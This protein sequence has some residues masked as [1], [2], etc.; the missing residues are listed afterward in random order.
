MKMSAEKPT[1]WLVDLLYEHD[2][3]TTDEMEGSDNM[4]DG[5]DDAQRAELEAT[6]AM[7]GEVRAAMPMEEPRASVRASILEAAHKQAEAQVAASASARTSGRRA[8][9]SPR[10]STESLWGGQNLY[11]AMSFAAVLCVLIG[12][13]VIAQRM[14]QPAMEA[15]F[16]EANSGVTNEVSFGGDSAPAPAR[17]QLAALEEEAET[18]EPTIAANDFPEIAQ[19][20]QT[21]LG[22]QQEDPAVGNKTLAMGDNKQKEKLAKSMDKGSGESWLENRSSRRE[23][24]A[25]SRAQAPKKDELD[26]SSLKSLIGSDDSLDE[27]NYRADASKAKPSKK[28]SSSKSAYTYRGSGS[29]TDLDALAKNDESY[30]QNAQAPSRDTN[31]LFGGAEGDGTAQRAPATSS[32]DSMAGNAMLDDVEAPAEEP[33]PMPTSEAPADDGGYARSTESVEEQ[34]SSRRFKIADRL[35]RNRDERK[36]SKSAPAPRKTTSSSTG[37]APSAPEVSATSPSDEQGNKDMAIRP[38]EQSEKKAEAEARKPA[39]NNTTIADVER[40]RRSEDARGTL[41]KA[42]AFLD[43]GIGTQQEKARALEL[44]ADALKELGR[45]SEADAVYRELERDYPQYYKKENVKEKKKR[46]KRKA[47]SPDLDFADEAMESF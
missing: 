15:K 32:K 4:S 36:T 42:D 40:A 45:K 6:F 14:S 33:A 17:P 5:L 29:G 18:A 16:S 2:E 41:E 46:S 27:D 3:A 37:P 39:P 43:R 25:R 34:K 19:N 20:R 38:V 12:A 21:T 8:P 30:D 31:R 22:I 13:G 35:R 9:G 47:A 1:E 10:S 23:S 7:L 24:S 44:K 28:R 11:R 26:S